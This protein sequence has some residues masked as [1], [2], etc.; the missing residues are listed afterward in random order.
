[1]L[2]LLGFHQAPGTA[3]LLFVGAGMFVAA[4]TTGPAGAMVA[5]LTHLLIHGTAFATLTLANNLL[6]MA[7]G[8][9]LTGVVADRMGLMAALQWLPADECGIDARGFC[10]RIAATTGTWT[11]LRYSPQRWR[12]GPRNDC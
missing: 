3:Q 6:G 5:N 7:P 4:G 1:M 11:G 9:F 12:H 10:L 8:P 2:L